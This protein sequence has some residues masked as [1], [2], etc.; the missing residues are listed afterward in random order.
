M[1]DA[2]GEAFDKTAKLLGLPYPGG[3]QCGNPAARGNAKRL[4]PA[5]PVAGTAVR[6]WRGFFLFR[7]E[8]RGAPIGARQAQ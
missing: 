7:I 8:D 5:A 3:P 4:C 2:V 1:D 6:Q